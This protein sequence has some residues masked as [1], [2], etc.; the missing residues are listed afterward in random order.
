VAAPINFVLPRIDTAPIEYVH[1]DPTFE[2]WFGVFVDNI[3]LAL[4]DIETEINLLDARLIAL[5]G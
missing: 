5:G 2:R 3:N 1:L 4:Q